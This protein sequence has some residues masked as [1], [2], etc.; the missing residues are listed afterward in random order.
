M[1]NTE[2]YIRQCI[3]SLRNQ[4]Y[5]NIEIIVVD[6][7]STDKGAAICRELKGYDDRIQLI[8]QENKGVSAARNAGLEIATGKYV[9]FWTVTMRSILFF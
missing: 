7:G 3:R 4:T 9:F 8:V 2:S 6:D 1:Y 5:D